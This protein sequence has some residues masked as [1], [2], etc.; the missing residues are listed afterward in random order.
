MRLLSLDVGDKTIGVAISEM[1]SW[2]SPITTI[3]RRNLEADMATLQGIIE[4]RD[5]ER[6]VIGLPLN[7]DDS[8][9]PRAAKTRRFAA[10]ARERFGVPIVLWDER[11]STFEADQ[12]L[13]EAGVPAHKRKAMIDMV[14]AQVI[15]EAYLAAGAP[16]RGLE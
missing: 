7:M 8:E 3:L 1:A 6:I 16:E 13:E 9:G 15:L 14:A 11:L 4:E 10:A 12:R 2:T 5:P